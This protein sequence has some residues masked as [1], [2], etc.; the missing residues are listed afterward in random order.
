LLRSIERRRDQNSQLVDNLGGQESA[1][2][3]GAAFHHEV[4]DAKLSG[5]HI[6]QARD[7]ELCACGDNV[8]DAV[9][10]KFGQ[11]A[12]GGISTNENDDVVAAQLRA[13]KVNLAGRVERNGER[14]ALVL[15]LAALPLLS[16]WV[17]AHAANL[18]HN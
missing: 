14:V 3:F 11:M 1:V 16:G 18:G 4:L 12:I 17:A 5:K 13:L 7:V 9:S 6:Q 15:W 8:R 10:R 2:R